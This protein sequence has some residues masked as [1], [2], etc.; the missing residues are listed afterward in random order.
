MTSSPARWTTQELAEDAATSSAQFRAERLALSDSWEMHYNSA[1]GKFELLFK[2]L[3]DLN[4]GAITNI[5]LHEQNIRQHSC[6]A[7]ICVAR[8]RGKRA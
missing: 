5:S 7:K 8:E 2:K 6:R 1:R 4:P 3:N